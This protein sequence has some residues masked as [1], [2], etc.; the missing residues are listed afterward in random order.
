MKNEFRGQERVDIRI[1]KEH[2]DRCEKEFIFNYL[3]SMPIEKLKELVN[4]S[5]I[6]PFDGEHNPNN[7]YLEMLIGLHSVELRTSIFI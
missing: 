6:N 2:K 3:K 5:V 1:Y 7:E 4:F